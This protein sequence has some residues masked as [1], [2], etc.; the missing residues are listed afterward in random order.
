MSD[1]PLPIKKVLEAFMQRSKNKAKFAEASIVEMWPIIV[2]SNIAKL[3]EK[4]WVSQGVLHIVINSSVLKSELQFHKE[5]IVDRVNQ[6]SINNKIKDI[7][8]H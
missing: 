3:T 7:I 1:S 6:Q 4:I 5:K 8:I 2:G